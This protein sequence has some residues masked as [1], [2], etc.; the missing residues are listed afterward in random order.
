MGTK[1]VTIAQRADG[2]V[3]PVRLSRGTFTRVV[4]VPH[5][6]VTR[7]RVVGLLFD[8]ARSFL[9]PSALDG[10]EQLVDLYRAH[11]GEFVLVTG[12]TDR[13]GSSADNDRL[14][15]DRARC[16]EAFLRDDVQVWVD[17]YGSSVAATS[18]WGATED[19]HMLHV[20][21]AD[22]I[23]EHGT[24][25]A[26]VRPYQQRRGLTVDGSI[27]PQTRRALVADYMAIDRSTLPASTSSLCHGCGEH[28]P[29]V[30]TDD[31]VAEPAN[32]RVEIFFFR[33]GIEPVPS[34]EQSGPGS[35]E[36]PA[37][38]SAAEATVDLS[39]EAERPRIEL[40]MRLHDLATAPHG[41]TFFVVEHEGMTLADGET[42]ER[43]FAFVLLPEP[44]P[45][46]VTVRFGADHPQGPFESA[47]V[48]VTALDP[49]DPQQR[50]RALLHNLGYDVEEQDLAGSVAQFQADY[51]LVAAAMDSGR[52]PAS[53][54][55]HLETIVGERGADAST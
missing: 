20:V 21:A 30:E 7:V 4:V 29:S 33:D 46:T 5:R 41:R 3:P 18:R 32:R 37:W 23:E 11:E 1:V 17:M 19:A 42:D 9:L 13:V 48:V 47:T 45:S 53:V 8:T 49:A 50:G 25:G 16:V 31:G 10:I 35:I 39:V 43:G 12:H 26:S 44:A 34:A 27:G 54:L 51:G 40:Q 38:R 52:L 36:Y 24:V 55:E 14:A 22:L 28:F 2:T 6:S 15:L